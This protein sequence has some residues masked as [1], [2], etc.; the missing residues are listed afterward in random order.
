MVDLLILVWHFLQMAIEVSPLT[1]VTP[2]SVYGVE[3]LEQL[4]TNL[5]MINSGI[6]T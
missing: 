4:G 1:E 6:S 5:L 3:Q 2:G